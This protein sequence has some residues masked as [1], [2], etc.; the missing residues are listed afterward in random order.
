[1]PGIV[2]ERGKTAVNKTSKI[3]YPLRIYSW[4]ADVA[5]K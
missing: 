5:A 1:M 4:V 2:L 3:P